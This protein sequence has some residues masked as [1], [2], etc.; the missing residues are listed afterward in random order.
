MFKQ[1]FKNGMKK[2]SKWQNTKYSLEEDTIKNLISEGFTSVDVIKLM[3]PKHVKALKLNMGQS[4]A[5]E[6]AL[7]SI[8]NEARIEDEEELQAMAAPSAAQSSETPAALQ[9]FGRR[10]DHVAGTTKGKR[11]ARGKWP[12]WGLRPQGKDK[13]LLV[14]DFVNSLSGYTSG[15]EREVLS[16]GGD[17]RLLV[18]ST[19]RVL[20]ES[21]TLPQWIRGHLR[22]QEELMEK[23]ELASIAEI[24]AY[25]KYGQKIADMCALYPL[26]RVMRFDAEYRI[27]VFEGL[28]KWGDA[29]PELMNFCIFVQYAGANN[30]NKLK[31]RDQMPFDPSSGKEICRNFNLQKGCRLQHCKFA[32]VCLKCNQNHPEFKHAWQHTVRQS[33]LTDKLDIWKRLL[34]NDPDYEFLINGIHNGFDIIDTD[35]TPELAFQTNNKSADVTYRDKVENAIIKEIELGRYRVVHEQ[36]RIVSPLGAVPKGEDEIRLLHDCSQPVDKA[37]ND[38]ATVNK[39]S[40]VSADTAV[41]KVTE[42]SYMAKV[43]LKFAYRQVPLSERSQSVA[44]LC[45][46]P[47]PYIYI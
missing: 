22:I 12:Q 16:L 3:S 18:S 38:Y 33:P 37:V 4:L 27:K 45:S 29:D 43:D 14:Q 19:R 17:Q 42:G 44:G 25:A 26:G 2:N 10:V 24:K 1:N 47:Y 32:H 23:G 36:P 11:L 28:L 30:N 9:P 34:L 20:P 31:K 35:A 39:H 40:F 15:Q 6:F 13:P 8:R 7:K 41:S 5:L 21:T 46:P